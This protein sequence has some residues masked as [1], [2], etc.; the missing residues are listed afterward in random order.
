[1]ARIQRY[2]LT[3]EPTAIDLSLAGKV[4]IRV[5]GDDVRFALNEGEL[6]YAYFTIDDGY[7]LVFDEPNPFMGLLWFRADTATATVEI[8]VSGG[9]Q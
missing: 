7:L 6:T 1:M 8:F 3:T 2:A 5:S 9:G 4:L